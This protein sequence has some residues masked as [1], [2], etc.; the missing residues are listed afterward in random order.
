L[1]GAN[2][3]LERHHILPF[4]VI[5]TTWNRLVEAFA[6]TQSS[7]ARTAVRQFISMC[8]LRLPNIEVTLD[9]LRA[10]QLDNVACTV[11]ETNAT[12]APWNIVYGPADRSDDP[13]DEYLDRFTFGITAA[14]AARM[15]VIETLYE[16]LVQFNSL[17]PPSPL[18]LGLLAETLRYTRSEIGPVDLPIPY[19]P[20][21]WERQPDGRW[22]KRRSGE[23]II[24]G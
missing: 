15:R 21:M 2:I 24:P 17:R 16:A 6:T 13:G 19:R 7:E 4:H 20:D 3:S 14:E 5:R 9:Q 22:A 8:G 18:S 23:Q 11:L 12:W 1:R 10:D